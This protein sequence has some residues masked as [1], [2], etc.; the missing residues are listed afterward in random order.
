MQRSRDF[1]RDYKS[2]SLLTFLLLF[3]RVFSYTF[4]VTRGTKVR[5]KCEF[6]IP[7]TSQ[8]PLLPPASRHQSRYFVTTLDK[9]LPRELP[10]HPGRM[11]VIPEFFFIAS[12]ISPRMSKYRIISNRRIRSRVPRLSPP[13]RCLAPHLGLV[14]LA[15][16]AQAIYHEGLVRA[17]VMAVWR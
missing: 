17:G 15:L 10:G 7:P 11:A 5:Y 4:F 16:L 13:R 6:S 1:P 9:K 14:P 3:P 12:W 2:T 8:P